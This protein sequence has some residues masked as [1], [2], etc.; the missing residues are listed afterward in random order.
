M[1]DYQKE[2]SEKW[3]FFGAFCLAGFLLGMFVG[4]Q[5][6]YLLTMLVI[7]T[8]LAGNGFALYIREGFE[9]TRYDYII[10][11]VFFLI[12]GMVLGM[13]VYFVSFAWLYKIVSSAIVVPIFFLYFSSFS[14][15]AGKMYCQETNQ[16]KMV[17]LVSGFELLLGVVFK[18][19]NA[20]LNIGIEVLFAIFGAGMSWILVR[21]W[22]WAVEKSTHD[23]SASCVVRFFLLSRKFLS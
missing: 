13:V 15:I 3:L 21:R 12:V 18:Y 8:A 5:P 11:V 19:I 16:K 20:D 23:L 7:M 10:P 6:E 22:Q 9:T 4:Y 17:L 1:S 14:V 2:F